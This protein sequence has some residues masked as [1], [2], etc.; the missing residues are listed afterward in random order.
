MVT[1]DSLN[2]PQDRHG[3]NLTD[4][5]L[6]SD[7]VKEEPKEN[8]LSVSSQASLEPKED[9]ISDQPQPALEQKGDTI[10][11]SSQP[12]LEPKGDV[13]PVPAQPTEEGQKNPDNSVSQ[14]YIR[15]LGSANIFSF[16][17]GRV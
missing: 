8:P 9:V 3:E 4:T 5:P 6:I 13:N 10:P 11:A 15:L 17:Q 12:D 7:N 14:R 1:G 2:V 16:F